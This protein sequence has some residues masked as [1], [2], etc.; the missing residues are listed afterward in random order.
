MTEIDRNKFAT[1]SRLVGLFGNKVSSDAIRRYIKRYKDYFTVVYDGGVQHVEI[2][3]GLKVLTVIHGAI[4]PGQNRGGHDVLDALNA[5]GI[6]PVQTQAETHD[7]PVSIDT[8]K[9]VKVEL[10]DKA[11]KVFEEIRDILKKVG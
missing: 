10:D 7:V 1:I 11:L 6:E 3:S 8:P 5:A 4:R 9:I 2:E